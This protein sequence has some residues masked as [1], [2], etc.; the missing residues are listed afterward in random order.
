[1]EE[2]THPSWLRLWHA[3]VPSQSRLLI[4]LGQAD[5]DESKYARLVAQRFGTEHKEL[6]LEPDVVGTVEKL[7]RSLEEPFGDSSMLPTYFVSRLARQHV[8]VALSGDG[9]DELFAGYKR[10]GIQQRREVFADYRRAFAVCIARN[11][12]RSCRMECGG[13]VFHTASRCP[14]KNVSRRDVLHSRVRL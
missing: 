10:Y 3:P 9:G 2:R 11:C 5:F 13:A 6:M 8:A 4:G 7:T 14:G 1:M 12:F